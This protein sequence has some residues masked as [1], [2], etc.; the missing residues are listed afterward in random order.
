M[1]NTCI[2]LAWRTLNRFRIPYL[3]SISG[4]FLATIAFLLIT[5]Y[6]WY[7]LSINSFHLDANRIVRINTLI[8][9]PNQSTKY[10]A[11]AF[12][13]GPDIQ[14]LY[15]DISHMV[16]I[17]A[18]PTTIDL[19]EVRFVDGLITYVDS[20]FFNVFSYKGT[21]I[22]PVHGKNNFLRKSIQ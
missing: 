1:L 9:L 16:R 2:K 17:R 13:V 22:N 6:I 20:A 4:L 21:S 3:I 18:M 14:S 7:H 5:R 12:D 15:P 11:T 19:G 8:D 10:A